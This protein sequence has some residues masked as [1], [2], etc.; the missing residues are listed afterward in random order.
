MKPYSLAEM[1]V[2]LLATMN[3]QALS[4]YQHRATK[5]DLGICGVEEFMKEGR[6]QS[7]PWRVVSPAPTS[8]RMEEAT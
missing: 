1:L 5:K 8:R 7:P 3:G 6:W 4:L 2:L